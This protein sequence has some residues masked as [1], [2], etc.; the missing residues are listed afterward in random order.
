MS[1]AP[2]GPESGEDGEAFN[3]TAWREAFGVLGIVA[4]HQSVECQMDQV[5]TEETARQV[6]QAFE[7]VTEPI[8][9][10]RE[11]LAE[12]EQQVSEASADPRGETEE[13]K[14]GI[15]WPETTRVITR[16]NPEVVEE[17]D[18]LSENR[19]EFIRRACQNEIERRQEGS[20]E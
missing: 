13:R 12:L 14:T 10:M 11:L 18:S 1:S 3:P 8:T 6:R 9:A 19:S 2:A 16:M 5:V 7:D 17:I 15:D 4:V 20:A